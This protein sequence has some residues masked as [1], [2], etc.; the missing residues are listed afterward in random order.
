MR[1]P[2][3]DEWFADFP[4]LAQILNEEEKAILNTIDPRTYMD[5][6]L[7]EKDVIR[8]I[9]RNKPQAWRWVRLFPNLKDLPP[10]DY[11]ILDHIYP[12]DFF[13][14]MT[15][16]G[17]LNIIQYRKKELEKEKEEAERLERE[18]YYKEHKEEIDRENRLRKENTSYA[19]WS[20]VFGVVLTTT[21][22]AIR[23]IPVICVGIA[24]TIILET[25]C[26]RELQKLNENSVLPKPKKDVEIKLDFDLIAFVAL[27]YIGLIG[28]SIC[29]AS[30]PVLGLSGWDV[31]ERVLFTGSLAISAALALFVIFLIVIPHSKE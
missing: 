12:G 10:E 29:L 20:L 18:Q 27:Y 9:N 15:E 31:A 16:E 24:T 17:L 8:I 4:N 1:R 19:K 28:F 22:V 23:S 26:T 14:E 2:F 3:I 6:Y 7:L 11:A 13:G 25:L 30:I 5:R 21:G